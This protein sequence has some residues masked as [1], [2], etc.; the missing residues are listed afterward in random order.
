MPMSTL[1]SK[2]QITLPAQV[3]RS[4]ELNAGDKVDFVADARGGFR[5][6]AVRADVRALRGRFSGRTAR[7]V[8]LDQMDAAIAAGAASRRNLARGSSRGSGS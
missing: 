4:L 8:T 1:T 3:R 2:G 5:L 7:P 6:V